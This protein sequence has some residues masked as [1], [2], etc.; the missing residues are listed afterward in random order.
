MIIVQ[1]PV[2]WALKCD[3]LKIDYM[4]LNSTLEKSI[5]LVEEYVKMKML[6]Y[7]MEY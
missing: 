3:E 7:I 4:F 5:E 2:F 6:K 1:F